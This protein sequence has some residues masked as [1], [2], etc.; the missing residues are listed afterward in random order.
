MFFD[1]LILLGTFIGSLLLTPLIRRFALKSRLV[2]VPNIRSSHERPT[3]RGGGLAIV[4]T[5][6]AALIGLFLIDYVP[7]YL[8]VAFAVAGLPVAAVGFWD[9]HGHVPPRWRIVVHF[10]AAISAWVLISDV[11]MHSRLP[12]LWWFFNVFLIVS[13]VWML[14]L[15]NFMDG[16]DAIAGAETIFVTA[17]AALLFSLS[18]S[19]DLAM[20]AALLAVST[21][22]FLVWNLPPARIFLGDVGSGFLGIAIGMLALAGI[23]SGTVNI[24]GWLIL[25]GVFLVDATL[26]VARRMMRGA[27]WYEA[28]RSH[29]YQHLAIRWKSH[30]KVTLAVTAINIFWLFPWAF[31][32]WRR[33]QWGALYTAL[34]LAPLVCAA[35]KLGAGKDLAGTTPQ[36]DASRSL[37][38]EQ[39]D[40]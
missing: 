26:T 36:P 12:L 29:A 2:D 34:A 8:V 23:K 14:N 13:V 37:V 7:L 35:L 16:I 40:L 28:H 21:T 15:Y 31:A 32:A 27:K 9:D 3:A 11:T 20:L 19:R 25:L 6:F 33:P 10:V 39:A 38:Y 1:L 24:W 18:G 30:G 22:G 17:G 5:Y 4:V